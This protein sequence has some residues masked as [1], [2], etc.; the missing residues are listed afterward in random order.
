[1]EVCPFKHRMGAQSGV[2]ELQQCSNFSPTTC[3]EATSLLLRSARKSWNVCVMLLLN[4]VDDK[5]QLCMSH[6]RTQHLWQWFTN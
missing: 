3:S 5:H 2:G 4:G 6:I 1:M